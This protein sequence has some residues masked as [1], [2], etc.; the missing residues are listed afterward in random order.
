MLQHGSE[1]LLADP[2]LLAHRLIGGADS[3]KLFDIGI[4]PHFEDS[5]SE[6]VRRLVGRLDGAACLIDVKRRPV[7]VIADISRCRGILSSSLHGLIVADAMGI[8]NRRLLLANELCGGDFKYE[9]YYSSFGEERTPIRLSGCETVGE[10]M[11]KLLPPPH[12]VAEKQQAIHEIFSHLDE[13]L[14]RSCGGPIRAT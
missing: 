1:V 4:V 9:D 2:G 13:H 6:T 10:L 5:H 12:G 7:D 14:A 8:P 3:S 11:S